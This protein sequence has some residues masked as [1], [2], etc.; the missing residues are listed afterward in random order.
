MNSRERVIVTLNHT[1]PDKVPIDLGDYV[2]GIHMV[3][4]RKRCNSLFLKI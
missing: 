3:A 2:T 1:E 4:Y